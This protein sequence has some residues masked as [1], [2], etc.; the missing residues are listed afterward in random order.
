MPQTAENIF[1]AIKFLSNE[2]YL[3]IWKQ[4]KSG[5]MNKVDMEAIRK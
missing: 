5:P 3:K 1:V 2:H 4:K